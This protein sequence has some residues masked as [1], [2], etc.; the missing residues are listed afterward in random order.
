MCLNDVLEVDLQVTGLRTHCCRLWRPWCH[1]LAGPIT[2]SGTLGISCIPI[3]VQFPGWAASLLCSHECHK[4]VVTPLPLRNLP[5]AS[6]V[7]PVRSR[8]MP[9][10]ADSVHKYSEQAKQTSKCLLCG[11]CANG[12]TCWHSD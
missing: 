10:T 8:A 7:A 9:V 2:M 5:F 6:L 11:G 4:A 12:H 3:Q 1:L